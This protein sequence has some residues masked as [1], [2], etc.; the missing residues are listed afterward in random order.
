MLSRRKSSGDP[1]ET[2]WGFAGSLDIMAKSLAS[3]F[4]WKILSGSAS[5]LAKRSGDLPQGEFPD[6][7]RRDNIAGSHGTY[8]NLQFPTISFLIDWSTR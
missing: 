7:F 5:D 8:K 2:L 6:D 4:F 3:P 1:P